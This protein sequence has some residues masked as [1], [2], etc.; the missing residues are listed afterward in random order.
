[1]NILVIGSGGREHA[2]AKKIKQD[3]P[4][5]AVYCCPGNPGMEVDGIQVCSLDASDFSALVTFAKEK[6][7]DLSIVGPEQPLLEGIVN[8]FQAAG[9]KIFGPTQEA[10]LLEGS[11]SFAKEVMLSANVPTASYQAFDKFE[12][13][14]LFLGEQKKYPIVIKADGL[15]AGKGV[16]IAQTKDEALTTVEQLMKEQIFG[17]SGSKIIIE[18]F[19]EGEE[20]TLMAFVDG[21]AVYPMIPAQDHKRVFAGDKGPNTGGMGA[22]APVPQISPQIIEA[23]IKNVL[24]PVA[25]YMKQQGTP[26]TGI[27]YAG[28]IVT[29]EGPKVIEFNARFGDPEA[30][31]VLPLLSS[32]LVNIM[33]QLLRHEPLEIV[34]LNQVSLGVVV[35]REGYP[36]AAKEPRPL[37]D[38]SDIKDVDV[39]YSGVSKREN[40][41]VSNGGRVFLVQKTANTFDEAKE[42]LYQELAQISSDDWHFRA[43]IGYRIN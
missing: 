8:H 20:F 11:K 35:A 40:R 26:Y 42:T 21:D 1:M 25:S 17:E 38:L 39:Y 2:I 22:Y 3:T 33:D 9:L 41:F 37:P 43:D 24:Q 13:A 18:E 29:A 12:D 6:E 7:I 30:Q 23:S 19:L 34:W 27:L 31:V 14:I 36:I 28:L 16:I 5:D 32:K 4:E 15:A 10:A